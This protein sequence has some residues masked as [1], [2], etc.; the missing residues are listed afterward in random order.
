[1]KL[2]VKIIDEMIEARSR[3]CFLTVGTM[4]H[5]HRLLGK[6]TVFASLWLKQISARMKQIPGTRPRVR[7]WTRQ[8]PKIPSSS[9]IS[10]HFTAGNVCLQCYSP[11]SEKPVG[12]HMTCYCSNTFLDQC[13]F[14]PCWTASCLLGVCECKIHIPKSLCCTVILHL[15][16]IFFK[17]PSQDGQ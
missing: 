8:L 11:N 14:W 5:Q 4:E 1:M 16:K 6:A 3:T 7:D 2:W 15:G 17:G 10:W 12:W 13:C 9:L